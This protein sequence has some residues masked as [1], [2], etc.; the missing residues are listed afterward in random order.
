MEYRPELLESKLFKGVS[1]EDLERMLGCIGA[2]V[3]NYV[4]GDVIV[5]VGEPI[6]CPMVVL[7]GTIKTAHV[8]NVNVEGTVSVYQPCEHFGMAY[9]VLGRASLVS[10][11]AVTACSILFLPYESMICTCERNCLGHVKVK[12]NIPAVLSEK[13]IMHAQKIEY[14]HLRSLRAKL[15][16]YLLDTQQAAGTQEFHITMSRTQL[17]E[18]LGASRASMTRELSVM[19]TEGLIHFKGHDF[20]LLDRERLVHSAYN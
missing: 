12:D 19:Q 7:E 6:P 18:Y 2:Y 10:A 17:A 5:G 16:A 15:S 9:A 13:V 3:R 8:S 1:Y 11:R 20:E 4:R 14:L